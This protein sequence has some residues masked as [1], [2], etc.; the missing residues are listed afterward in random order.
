MFNDPTETVRNSV[1]A[2]VGFVEAT[3]SAQKSGDSESSGDFDRK[4]QSIAVDFFK[5]PLSDYRQWALLTL[6]FVGISLA[7]IM[8][9]V[10]LTYAN[11]MR[12]ETLT[13]VA[14]LVSSLIA[15]VFY[16]RLVSAQKALEGARG[17]VLRE[18]QSRS[19]TVPA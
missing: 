11:G 19:G 14:S 16:T 5:E 13:S 15:A 17:E 18:L 8:V 2:A 3:I 10:V 7:S 6:V 9:G 1:I 12:I 4:L